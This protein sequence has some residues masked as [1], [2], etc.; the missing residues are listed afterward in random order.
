[1][2]KRSGRDFFDVIVFLMY[3]LA[4]WLVLY[5][6]VIIEY[7]RFFAKCLSETGLNRSLL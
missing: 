1:M 7:F 5:N 2:V 6:D 4:T 3:F